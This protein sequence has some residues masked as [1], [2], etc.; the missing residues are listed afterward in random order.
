MLHFI[1]FHASIFWFIFKKGPVT[2]KMNTK[3]SWLCNT[4]YYTAENTENSSSL[5]SAHH[6]KSR[7][8]MSHV[9]HHRDRD[10]WNGMRQ[11]D[12][13]TKHCSRAWFRV[14]FGEAGVHSERRRQ[15]QLTCALFKICGAERT[16]ALGA[17]IWAYK[18]V[19]LF[20]EGRSLDSTSTRQQGPL[21][22]REQVSFPRVKC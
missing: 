9:L 11:L 2:S 1:S 17:L 4:A 22:S 14:T 15:R 13:C 19:S 12:S 16:K 10:C 5:C 20:S 6:E 21:N 3:L 8:K 7:V 18:S